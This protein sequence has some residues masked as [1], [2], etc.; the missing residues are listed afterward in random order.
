MGRTQ[1]AILIAD[2]VEIVRLYTSSRE[3]L[4]PNLVILRGVFLK[5]SFA[6]YDK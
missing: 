5:G 4:G 3:V 6:S 2:R 1:H